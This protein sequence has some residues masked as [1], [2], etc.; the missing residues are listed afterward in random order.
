MRW[1]DGITNSMDMSLSK[2][3]EIVKD[4][5]SLA[6]CSP[7]DCKEL[8]TNEQLMNTTTHGQTENYKETQALNDTLDK[9]DLTDIYRVF[10]LKA[11]YAVFSSTHETFCKIDNILSD[12][13][14]LSK[15][16]KIDIISSIFSNHDTMRL[17]INY[18]KK[19]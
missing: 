16:K 5:G 10:P 18:R 14:S 3:Q 7:W 19:L 1:L 2:L 6:C 9:I 15:F 8:D 4:K 12:T 11:A 17:E 13:S